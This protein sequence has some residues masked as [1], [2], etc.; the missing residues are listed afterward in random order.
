M[1]NQAVPSS[2]AGGVTFFSNAGIAKFLSATGDSV[3]LSS[4]TN[5]V[6]AA[7]FVANTS[8]ISD[9]SATFGGFTIGQIAQALLNNGLLK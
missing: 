2:V 4:Q 5:A 6:G 1:A 8:G 3:E 9:D 7:T